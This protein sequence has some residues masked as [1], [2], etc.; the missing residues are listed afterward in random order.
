MATQNVLEHLAAAGLTVALVGDKLHVSPAGLLTDDLRCLIRDGRKSI[1]DALLPKPFVV[2]RDRLTGA[3][4]ARPESEVLAR[5]LIGRA[6]DRDDRRICIECRHLA[7]HRCRAG[8]MGLLR[9]VQR[10]I[11]PCRFILQRCEAFS[12]AAP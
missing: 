10:D 7:G 1:V 5:V 11:E 6:A 3:G 4:L 12:G 8:G 9:G 2:W